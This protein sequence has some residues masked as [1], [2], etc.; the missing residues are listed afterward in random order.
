MAARKNPKSEVDQAVDKYLPYILEIRKRILFLLIFFLVFSAIGFIYYEKVITLILSIFALEGVNIVFTSPFQFLSLAVNTGLL[1]GGLV[2]FPLLVFQILSFLKPALSKKEFKTISFLIP[3]SVILFVCGFLFGT[4][5]M[6]YV[7]VIFYEKTVNL[8]IG[9]FL[10]ITLLIS[11]ILTTS[12]LMGVAFQFP[13]FITLLI[14]LGVVKYEFFAKKRIF[15][16]A[17]SLVFATLLPP[18]DMLSLVFLTLP[19][20]ALYEITLF[21]NGYIFKTAPA[22]Q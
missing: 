13:I 18:T 21:A 11:Q 9:N 12:L 20:I 3:L 1:L 16:Y 14:K 5:I 8:E 10:D 2:V 19:L 7:V 17:I 6:R 22:I 4:L 15:A